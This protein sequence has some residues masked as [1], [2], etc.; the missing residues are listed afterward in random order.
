MKTDGG[1]PIGILDDLKYPSNSITLDHG[2]WLVFFTDGLTESF[3]PSDVL[4]DREGVQTI[5]RHDFASASDIIGR[6]R[7]GEAEHRQAAEPGDDLTL[8]VFGFR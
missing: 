6:L 2:D 5:L 1:P 3:N 4:L 7:H 8:L